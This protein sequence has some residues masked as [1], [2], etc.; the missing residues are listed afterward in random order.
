MTRDYRQF[1]SRHAARYRR[2]PVKHRAAS[3]GA[4][5]LTVLICSC[6]SGP[7]PKVTTGAPPTVVCGTVLSTG[8][9]GPVVYD[10]TRHLP[11]I[12]YETVGNVVIFRVASSCDKG[13]RVTWVPSSAAHLVKAAYA[14]D[15]NMAAVVL[16]PNRPQAAFQLIATR[17]G[18]TVASATVQLATP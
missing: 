17:N 3:A 7:A 8:A 6:G 12:K 15:G 2:N 14:K 13:A 16:K 4:A 11:T 18:K 10:A 5:V 1:R 9:A